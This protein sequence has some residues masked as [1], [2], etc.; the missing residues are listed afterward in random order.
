[1][2]SRPAHERGRARWD[3]TQRSCLWEQRGASCIHESDF[4]KKWVRR[5]LG[6]VTECTVRLA[7]KQPV[8]VATTSFNSVGD[9]VRT[10]VEL[11]NKGVQ[12][13]CVEL[14][15][16]VTMKAIN[17]SGQI[18]RKYP[19]VPHLFSER[20]HEGL[21]ASLTI[22]HSQV[23]GRSRSDGGQCEDDERGIETAQRAAVVHCK[24]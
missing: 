14:L 18:A 16:D 10:V 8:K 1:M 2:S 24:K 13:T 11:L 21:C 15:D 12:L 4:A 17:L 23:L 19:E 22:G 6:I 9:A 5:T 7:P 3:G 20:T